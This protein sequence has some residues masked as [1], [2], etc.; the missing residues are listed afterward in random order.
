MGFRSGV[1]DVMVLLLREFK[2]LHLAGQPAQRG[3][4]GKMREAPQ[5]S[6]RRAR[7]DGSLKVETERLP[8]IIQR[9]EQPD[10]EKSGATGDE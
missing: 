9:F 3:M 7:Q 4:S 1:D 8:G 2:V 10:A 6:V 5:E